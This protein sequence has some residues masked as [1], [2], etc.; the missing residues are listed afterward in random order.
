MK[1]FHVNRWLR[2]LALGLACACLGFTY[3]LATSTA[4]DAT[5]GR[6]LD[7]RAITTNAVR[8]PTTFITNSDLGVVVVGTQFTRQILVQF[9]FKPHVF[10]FGTTKPT[11]T[12]EISESGTLSGKKTGTDTETFEVRVAESPPKSQ[13][14]SLRGVDSRQDPQLALQFVN[15]PV[16][17][18]AVASEPYTF[19]LHANGGQ[20]PYLFQFDNN[21][22]IESLPKGLSLVVE[23]GEIFGKPVAP[24]DTSS[25]TMVCTDALGTEAR[26][27]FSLRVLPGTISSEFIATNG[28]FKLNFGSQDDADAVTLTM[29]LNKTELAR[30]HIRESSDLEG[31]RFSMEFGGV[32]IPPAPTVTTTGTTPSPTPT[33]GATTGPTFQRTFDKAGSLR[34]PSLLLGNLPVKGESR[35]YEVSLNAKT[36][37]LKIKASGFNMIRAL[38][39]NFSSFKDPIIPVKVRIG[40][41]AAEDDDT[42]ATPATP[43]TPATTT[44]DGTLRSRVRFDK[45]DVIKFTYRRKGSSGFGSARANDKR[46]PAGLF[47]IT[48][49]SGTEVKT[50]ATVDRIIMRFTGVIRGVGGL[51]VVF[52]ASDTV[53]IFLGKV[54][55]GEF[56]ATSLKAEGTKLSFRNDDR[57]AGLNNFEVDNKKGTLDFDTHPILPGTLFGD[58][59]LEGGV[60]FVLPITV[61]IASPGET[62][63][64]F[65]GQSSVT[66]F[67]RGN[68]LKNK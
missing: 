18:V 65:D 60:P 20:P 48:R 8:R 64:S 46:P 41:F 12:I 14:F 13:L 54:N 50:A 47:L 2:S 57:S 45:T 29:V 62:I 16:L 15:D 58:D 27:T 30:N 23:T 33:P 68:S 6:G 24:Q 61:T 19:T 37:V 17:P 5:A 43:T 51:P 28:N 22:D 10:L 36:G 52:K 11:S 63:P 44:T 56:P 53:A 26:R 59:I 4:S 1:M 32:T 40:N 9:G 34:F 7:G 67:R 21:V 55:I 35:R 31:I 49:A 39:A 66:L 3:S 38:G 42:T 25:F